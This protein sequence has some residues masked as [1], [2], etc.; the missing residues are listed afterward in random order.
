[1]SLRDFR[2]R[3]VMSIVVALLGLACAQVSAKPRLTVVTSF[4]PIYISA[5]NVT[6]GVDGLELVNLTGPQT[7]CL[8]DYQLTPENM[9]VLERA[10]VFII[11][12]A[13]MEAFLGKVIKGL[14]KLK[15]IDAS[16]GILM[17]KNESDGEDNPHVWVSVTGNIEQVK[18]IG[19]RMA[20]CDPTSAKQYNA[21]TRGYV[22]QLDALRGK[23][24]RALDSVKHK[25]IVTFHEAFPY[26]AKEFNLNIK[27]VIE[28]E[29]G[30]EPS[31]AELAE[32][33][34]I[35]RESKCK[36][37]FAE[38]Q[39]PAKA[40]T[41]IANETGARVYTLDP[42]VTGPMKASAYIGI[43]EGNLNTLQKALK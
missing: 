18:N 37:L 26:F 31:A 1:M 22:Q 25:D 2:R 43:M 7:G 16:K 32:T 30:A 42:V 6:S 38:P 14:P 20:V 15:I 40:A 27:A 8:H 21:N 23:M 13:G 17:L 9:R 24:H 4:Y 3:V 39:Y 12:G 5:M 10:D 33:I 34:D 36:A 29:P 11:N 19:A 41:T 35:V 28:R